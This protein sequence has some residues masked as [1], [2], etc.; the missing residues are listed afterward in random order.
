MIVNLVNVGS[1]LLKKLY[2]FE[3]PSKHGVVQARKAL[4]IPGFEPHVFGVL[5]ILFGLGFDELV[6]GFQI[7]LSHIHIVAIGCHMQ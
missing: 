7:K 6:I 5:G 2:H 1:I 4:I 3:V